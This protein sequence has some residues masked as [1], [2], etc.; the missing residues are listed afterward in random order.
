MSTFRPP[1]TYADPVVTNENTRKGQFNPIWLK[2]F[3]DITQ[4]INSNGGTSATIQHNSLGGLQGG[5]TVNKDYYHLSFS[6][7]Q[8]VSSIPTATAGGIAYGT[9]SGI[10]FTPA[11]TAG[12]VLTSNGTGTPTWTNAS[13]S[14]TVTSVGLSLPSQ[15]T[16]TGSPVTGSGTLTAAWASEVAN[17]VFAG[18]TSGTAAPT[19]RALVAADI[20][21]LSYAPQTSGTSIL[22]GNGSGGFSNVTIGANLSFTGGV[23]SATGGGGGSS[24]IDGG[25]S[26][27]VFGGTIGI[28]GGAASTI[29]SGSGIDGGSA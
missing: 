29:F 10:S 16:V 27:S 3:L 11:G 6:E 2:W 7:Y 9:G 4:F 15:F 8:F 14:G 22:Y 21:A 18:P 25:S 20:P 5:D 1:P 24:N 12:Q 19:F 28:D 26:I 13:G 17:V 23:L